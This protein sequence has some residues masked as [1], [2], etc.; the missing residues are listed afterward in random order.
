MGSVSRLMRI[1]YFAPQLSHRIEPTEWSRSILQEQACEHDAG[2]S[3]PTRLFLAR[4]GESTA[5]G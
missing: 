1:E 3:G 2:R 5:R 4:M